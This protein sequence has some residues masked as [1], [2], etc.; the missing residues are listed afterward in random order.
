MTIRNLKQILHKKLETIWYSPNTMLLR[1]VIM[2]AMVAGLNL[3]IY[4]GSML[5]KSVTCADMVSGRW[6]K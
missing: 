2:K 4:T 5:V 1:S 6:I 3:I